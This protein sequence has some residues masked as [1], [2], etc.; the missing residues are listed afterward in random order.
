M[1]KVTLA[2]LLVFATSA[3]SGQ[4]LYEIDLNKID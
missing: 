3:V 2:L 4:H 1:K